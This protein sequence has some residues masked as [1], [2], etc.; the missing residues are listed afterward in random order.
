MFSSHE[1]SVAVPFRLIPYPKC[2]VVWN[3]K[4]GKDLLGVRK[5]LY[6]D[7]DV[8]LEVPNWDDPDG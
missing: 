4:R 7:Q 8:H 2:E 3:Q 6:V 1:H 5:L